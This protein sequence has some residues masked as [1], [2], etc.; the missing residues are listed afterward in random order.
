M[1]YNIDITDTPVLER[2]M[3]SVDGNYLRHYISRDD[4]GKIISIA[5]GVTSMLDA[6]LPTSPQL[7][8][9]MRSFGSDMAYKHAM[10]TMAYYGTIMHIVAGD[11][12][13]GSPLMLDEDYIYKM[14]KLNETDDSLKAEYKHVTLPAQIGDKKYDV[15]RF[16]RDAIAIY[17]FFQD[18]HEYILVEDNKNIVSQELALIGIETTFA[19]FVEGYAGTCD[20]IFKHAYKVVGEHEYEKD[21]EYYYIFDLKTGDGHY[22][23]HDIQLMFYR[24]LVANYFECPNV[25]MADVHMKDY[26]QSTLEKYLNGTSKT[27]PYKI[28]WV[29][30]DEEKFLHFLKTYRILYGTPKVGEKEINYNTT[31]ENVMKQIKGEI[32]ENK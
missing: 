13:Q 8:K 3:I 14:F 17:Q 18:V 16:R 20:F 15:A 5:T 21:Y 31:I 12:A 29:E 11:I 9:F 23:S 6:V 27:T 1:N 26:R 19:N 22:L 7:K 28:E 24:N 2:K 4:K 10:D 32:G 25:V 30:Y